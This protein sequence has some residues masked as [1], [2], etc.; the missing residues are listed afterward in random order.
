MELTREEKVK[1]VTGKGMWKTK[2]LGGKVKSIHLSDGPHGLRTQLTNSLTDSESIPATCFPTASALA[3][4]FDEKLMEELAEALALEA[5]ERGVDILLGPGINI[6]RHPLGGRNFEYFSEDPYL[7]G[8]L[9]I[10]YIKK[11]QEEGV[12]ASLKHFAGN[13]QERRRQT[14][15]SMIDERALREIYLKAFE[16]VVKEAEPATIMSSYNRLGGIHVNESKELQ[17]DILRGE[18]G[19]KGLIVSDWGAVVD[20]SKALAAGLDLEMPDSAGYHEKEVLEDLTNNILDEEHLDRAT[21]NIIQLSKT[22]DNSELR[23]SHHTEQRDI[24]EKIAK[25]CLVLLKNDGTLPLEEDQELVIVGDLAEEIRFQGGGSSHI[26]TR[27][28]QSI[29]DV[30]DEKEISFRFARGYDQGSEKYDKYMEEEA[31]N[32]AR[33]AP[34]VLYFAGLTEKREG[35]S[36]DR[37]T[38]SLPD[39]QLRLY[40]KLLTA[41]KNILVVTFGGSPFDMVFDEEA[42]AILHAYLGGEAVAKAIVDTLYGDNNPSGKLA[43]T[44]PLRLEDIPSTETFAKDTDDVQYRESI[45]V[46][47]RYFNT[48]NKKVRY[49]FGYG[50]SYTTFSYSDLKVSDE[51]FSD[52]EIEVSLKVKNTGKRTGKEIVQLY[53]KNPKENFMRAARELKGFKKIE[54]APGEEKEVHFT[55]GKDAFS[56]YD[57]KKREF[58][59]SQGTYEIEVGASV[60]DIRL[61]HTLGVYGV[62]S[63]YDD[64]KTLD[65][66]LEDPL[67]SDETSF[68]ILYGKPLSTFDVVSPGEFTK[69]HSLHDLSKESALARLSLSLIKKVIYRQYRHLDPSDPEVQMIIHGAT[70]GPINVVST[71]SDGHFPYRLQ[72]AIIDFANKKPK[73]GFKK[74][75][76]G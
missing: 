48:F 75:I 43:E 54:L 3:C 17:W 41:N 9:A 12:G 68:K 20:L 6:K 64:R 50:L 15:N 62:E 70:Y 63:I 22:Y 31:V 11:L 60:E 33:K 61:S 44:W 32:L 7:T 37:K 1:L 34:L 13:N 55:L 40:Y 58:V 26:R 46:G 56:I 16:M 69:Y 4:S 57:K 72:K 18:W 25:E 14:Q 5:K 66:Y 10:S 73:D 49:P 45:F 29:L 76:G 47:Y 19:Y 59:V 27:R 74:L 8:R 65:V 30:L 42:K 38:L 51:S 21:K 71:Q 24:A 52:K 2:T 53:V 23:T 28:T 35:E 36:Y 39:N 67:R